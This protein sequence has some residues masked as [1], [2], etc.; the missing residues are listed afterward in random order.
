MGTTDLNLLR[1]FVA[2]AETSSFSAAAKRLDVPKSSVSRAVKRLE[3]EL[4][5]RLVHRTTRSVALSTAGEGLYARVSVR[6][7]D[8]EQALGDLPEREEEPSGELRVTA[9][10][11]FG[12]VVLAD[13]V[14]KFVAR[15]PAVRVDM[16]LSNG[17]VDLV[18][19][20]FD[21]AFRISMKRLAD[22]SLHAQKLAPLA[23]GLY[24]S[25]TYLARRGAPRAPKDLD[26]HDWV[27]FRG[28][29]EVALASTDGR[30]TAKAT[31]QGPVNAD[32]MS[33]VHMA[34]RA[35]A[36]IG[37]MPTFLVE[38]DVA[39][40][41]LVRVLPKWNAPVGDLYV[42]HPGGARPPKKVVAFRDFVRAQLVARGVAP[43]A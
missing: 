5:A 4:G 38:A 39:T 40:G 28:R 42:V 30:G 13:V 1:A 6:L 7:R 19:E 10:V 17:L 27:T 26:D 18:A 22:S 3:E 41:A 20:G 29:R 14:A 34:V 31:S 9:A 32:D 23:I 16:H 2:V 15:Y 21:V 35:G 33:F 8:L 25:P 36:G 43:P 24:A 11:D 12:S 37:M